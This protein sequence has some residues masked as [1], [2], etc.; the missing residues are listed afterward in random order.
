VATAA[1][2]KIYRTRPGSTSITSR[3][4]AAAFPRGSA[5]LRR[6]SSVRKSIAAMEN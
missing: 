2:G 5:G 4:E 1:P 3:A 6:L